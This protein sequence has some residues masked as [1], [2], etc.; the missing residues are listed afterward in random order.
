M[1]EAELGA[2][3]E[4]LLAEP[5]L[6][7]ELREFENE[8]I[9]A[10]ARGELGAGEAAEVD[11]YL[12]ATGQQGRLTAALRLMRAPSAAPSRRKPSVY[13]LAAAAAAIVLFIF[14][15][16][17]NRRAA[18]PRIDVAASPK[19]VEIRPFAVLLTPGTR[20]AAPRRVVTPPDTVRIEL[21]L[22]LDAPLPP[23]SYEAKV[24]SA[25]GQAVLSRTASLSPGATSLR[26]TLGVE[27]LPAG[28]YRVLVFPAANAE[29]VVNIYAFELSP[30]AK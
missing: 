3:G 30:A 11:A 29:N 21:Q 28:S 26:F 10:R 20:G 17:S 16:Q 12:S 23:G 22:A 15:W 9:D 1:P 5:E 4:R 25:F 7:D 24:Q 13:W 18:N 27:E 2:F 14:A 8:W 6:S 19:P